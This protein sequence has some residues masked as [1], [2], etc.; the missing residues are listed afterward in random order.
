MSEIEQMMIGAGQRGIRITAMA[1]IVNTIKTEKMIHF[2]IKY[3]RVSN[4]FI[5]NY[6]SYDISYHY[7]LSKISYLFYF[8]HVNNSQQYTF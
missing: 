6:L 7:K 4:L 5:Y 1:G 2:S 8:Y 3:F